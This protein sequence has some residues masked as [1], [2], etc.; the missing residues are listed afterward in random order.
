[1]SA[2]FAWWL[3]AAVVLGGGLVALYF[4][5]RAARQGEHTGGDPSGF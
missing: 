5:R 1:M 4:V 2:D 3:L